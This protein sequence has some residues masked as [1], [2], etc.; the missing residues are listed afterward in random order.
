MKLEN[1]A[2][3]GKT[4][5]AVPFLRLC[6]Q[7]MLPSGS[8]IHA[9]Q[10]TFVSTGPTKSAQ[11]ALSVATR[12]LRTER[13]TTAV[14]MGSSR[15][16][17]DQ[18]Q[19]GWTA[20]LRQGGILTVWCQVGWHCAVTLAESR[21]AAHTWKHA[22]WRPPGLTSGLAAVGG[23]EQGE[24]GEDEDGGNHGE[25]EAPGAQVSRTPPSMLMFSPMM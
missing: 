19:T 21:R 7:I 10:Q 9:V 11:S 8:A 1:T 25:E 17:P 14:I 13:M 6:R 24:G 23:D 16:R 20:G 12:R 2:G 4:Q 3:A 22:D 15:V 5:P 18:A